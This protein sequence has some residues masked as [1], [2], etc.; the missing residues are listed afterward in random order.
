[1]QIWTVKNWVCIAE[2]PYDSA[3]GGKSLPVLKPP[4]EKKWL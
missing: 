4:E 3:L 1:M 2:L